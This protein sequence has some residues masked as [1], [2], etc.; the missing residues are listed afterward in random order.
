[1]PTPRPT[2]QSETIRHSRAQRHLR[3]TRPTDSVAAM[4]PCP[5]SSRP[6]RSTGG[7]LSTTAPAQAA[8]AM[9]DSPAT[10][11]STVAVIW[12][13][14]RR[15]SSPGQN[16]CAGP[17]TARRILRLRSRADERTPRS[18]RKSRPR[19]ADCNPRYFGRQRAMKPLRSRRV[20]PAWV[21]QRQTSPLRPPVRGRPGRGETRIL[22]SAIARS[23]SS[24][25]VPV[26]GSAP[27][28]GPDLKEANRD[29]TGDRH[30]LGKPELAQRSVLHQERSR[31]S[32]L[33]N[34][35]AKLLRRLGPRFSGRVTCPLRKAG[36]S[37]SN[38]ARRLLCP[39]A[40]ARSISA[41]P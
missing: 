8:P 36:S 38:A 22:A 19:R 21:P 31:Q 13:D 2:H 3:P 29:G 16:R 10:L 18:L 32:L 4:W 5:R 41:R 39:I 15:A 37:S 28:A 12:R 25:L 26:G 40:R 7:G 23:V 20:G 24:C 27:S 30:S 14:R 1:M 35:P 9:R 6:N 11:G 34:L 17:P 33:T